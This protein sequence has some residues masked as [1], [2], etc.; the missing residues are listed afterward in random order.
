MSTRGRLKV[1]VNVPV[2][3][4]AELIFAPIANCHPEARCWPKDLPGWAVLIALSRLFTRILAREL[5]SANEVRN[6]PGDPSA[7]SGLRMTDVETHNC[8]WATC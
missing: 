2:L 5:G 1:A 3:K 7:K 4:S 6:I 8:L